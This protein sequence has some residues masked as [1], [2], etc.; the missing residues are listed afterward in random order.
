VEPKKT[1]TLVTRPLSCVGGI[2][3]ELYLAGVSLIIW[4]SPGLPLEFQD[5]LSYLPMHGPVR[6]HLAFFGLQE[7]SDQGC[8]EQKQIVGLPS[9]EMLHRN[10]PEASSKP[11]QSAGPVSSHGLLRPL[12]GS[13]MILLLG[14]CNSIS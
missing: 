9:D 4:S 14:D 13:Q 10:M 1:V 8:R 2:K 6:P 11:A 5:M 12:I 3:G 7:F